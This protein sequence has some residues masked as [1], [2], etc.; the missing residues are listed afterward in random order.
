MVRVPECFEGLL[1][2]LVVCSCVHEEH[3]QKHDVACDTPSL[4]VVNIEGGLG[5]DLAQ[6]D[7]E[8]TVER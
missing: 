2:D 5:A 6:F 3:A 7:V 1:A 8:E 4:G